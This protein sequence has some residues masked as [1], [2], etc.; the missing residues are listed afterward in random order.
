MGFHEEIQEAIKILESKLNIRAGFLDTLLKEDDWSFVIK[1]HALLE[2]VISTLITDRVGYNRLL[3]I[4]ARLE[5]GN[6]SY[7]KI[8]FIKDLELLNTD[9]RRFISALAELR[10][11]LIHNVSNIDF[12]F[13]EYIKNLDPNQKKN[14]IS[15]FGYW[16]LDD[17]GK[18]TVDYGDKILAAPK[19]TI[20]LSLKYILAICS[21]IIDTIKLEK[22]TK[23]H[24]DKQLSLQEGIIEKYEKLNKT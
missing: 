24:K 17:K 12:S 18:S 3:D 7:G 21:L 10:N 1:S 8:A 14:F 4:F 2:T 13:S 23:Q 11:L 5:I 20:W 19:E 16:Y 9:E 22:E 15:S 6:K